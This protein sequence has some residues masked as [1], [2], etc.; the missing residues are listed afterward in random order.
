[1]LDS[2]TFNSKSKTVKRISIIVEYVIHSMKQT[3]QHH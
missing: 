1:M 2:F 3:F